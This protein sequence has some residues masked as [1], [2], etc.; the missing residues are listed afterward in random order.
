MAMCQIQV[1]DDPDENLRQVREALALAGDVD[2]AVF[3]EAVHLRFGNDLAKVAEPLDGAFVGEL[4]RAA[5]EHGT[6]LVAGV[7]EPADG[8]RVYNTAVAID[9]AGDLVASYRKMHLFDAFGDRESDRVA[10]GDWPVVV[11]LAGVRL[12]LITCYDVRFPELAR[13][14]VERGADVLVVIAAWGQGVFKEEHWTTLVRARAIENTVWVVAVDKAPDRSRPLS[15]GPG[16]VGRS[17]LIDPMGTV[18]A[19]LGPFPS[20]RVGEIDTRVT[21]HVRGILPALA[22]RRR[23]VL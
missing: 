16:G 22:H 23:D 3:P 7:F 21:E 10:A 19:D 6:A 1:G 2:L 11:D 13:A 8:D 9:A 12:G 14:L 18:L 17:M 20:V 5:R 4:R 15:G